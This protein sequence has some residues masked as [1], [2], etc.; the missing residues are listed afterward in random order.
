MIFANVCKAVR[1][2]LYIMSISVGSMLLAQATKD[3]TAW[4]P[5]KPTK[6]A[7]TPTAGTDKAKTTVIIGKQREQEKP[8][9]ATP[10]KKSKVKSA[11]KAAQRAAPELI[12]QAP[13]LIQSVKTISSGGA[14]TNTA[15]PKTERPRSATGTK[16]DDEDQDEDQ[17]EEEDEDI[18]D[19]EDER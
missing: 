14:N 13:A 10:K 18:Q 6:V 2:T 11:L 16:E 15:Q 3:K 8:A 12:K 9:G 1:T 4:T 7:Q 5:A 19:D 17:D